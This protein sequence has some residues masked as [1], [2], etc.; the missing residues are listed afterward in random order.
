MHYYSYK[1][2]TNLYHSPI[3][4]RA[5]RASAP[6]CI[7]SFGAWPASHF[8]SADLL[9]SKMAAPSACVRLRRWRSCLSWFAK[10]I[11]PL[12]GS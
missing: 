2:T 12:R 7:N 9:T 1:C 6:S 8:S 3:G 5:N 11:V 10:L 4:N